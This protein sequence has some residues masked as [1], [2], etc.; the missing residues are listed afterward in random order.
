MAE[1]QGPV[2]MLGVG[3]GGTVLPSPCL[4]LQSDYS[5]DEMLSN[6]S[7]TCNLKFIEGI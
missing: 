2:E 7:D 3:A 5:L 4:I 1:L 6:L